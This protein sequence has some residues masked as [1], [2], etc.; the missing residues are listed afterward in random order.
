MIVWWLQPLIIQEALGFDEDDIKATKKVF[1]MALVKATGDGDI[2]CPPIV[3]IALDAKP[4]KILDD[5]KNAQVTNTDP[6]YLKFKE[7]VCGR[8]TVKYLY[9]S[10]KEGEITRCVINADESITP[11]NESRCHPGFISLYSV[12]DQ[13]MAK[14][15]AVATV[16]I[17]LINDKIKE[18]CFHG[19]DEV[20]ISCKSG[21]GTEGCITV[22][23]EAIDKTIKE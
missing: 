13:A 19:S 5:I 4:Q 23:E 18:I 2:A 7:G 21:P 16:G 6:L 12:K 17:A 3:Y 10:E 8:C 9:S 11:R 1:K 20:C 15:A 22:G 14:A